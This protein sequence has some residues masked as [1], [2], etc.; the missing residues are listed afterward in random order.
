MSGEKLNLLTK[1]HKRHFA[2]NRGSANHLSR[3]VIG[4][5]ASNKHNCCCVAMVQQ[6]IMHIGLAARSRK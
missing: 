3:L 4:R 6:Q 2:I 1:R 5:G